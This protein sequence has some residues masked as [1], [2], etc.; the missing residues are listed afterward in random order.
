M[1]NSLFTLRCLVENNLTGMGVQISFINREY[2][3]NER[4]AVQA[5]KK[6]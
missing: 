6:Q 5:K 2:M 1:H 4:I 3:D